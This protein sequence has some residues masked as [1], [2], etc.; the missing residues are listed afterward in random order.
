MARR[1]RLHVQ[2]AVDYHED[3]RIIEAGEKAELLYVRCLA[4]CKRSWETDG[5]IT[6]GQLARVVGAGLTGVKA[7]TK[8]LVDLGLLERVESDLLGTG[9]GYQ[10]RAWLKWNPSKADIAAKRRADVD[11][12][13]P[14]K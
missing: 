9:K 2:L 4:F 13:R 7:S 8:R 3:D 12:K 6:D 1:A 10:V 5:F 14:G 11:R